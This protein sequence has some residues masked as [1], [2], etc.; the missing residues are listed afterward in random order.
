MNRCSHS[1]VA[2]ILVFVVFIYGCS[3]VRMVT[4]NADMGNP[5]DVPDSTNTMSHMP[6]PPPSDSSHI[7]A[8]TLIPKIEGNTPTSQTGQKRAPIQEKVDSPH[9]TTPICE[10]MGICSV[11]P[12]TAQGS[13]VTFSFDPNDNNH[14]KITVDLTNSGNAFLQSLPDDGLPHPYNFSYKFYFPVSPS[15]PNG[16]TLMPLN[17][18]GR[19]IPDN[20]PGTATKAQGATDVV[21]IMP[22]MPQ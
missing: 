7:P 14:I 12:L 13:H 22:L 15:D 16:N 19:Y 11:S 4:V 9:Q 17:L 2:F 20:M 21:I 3:P 5:S 6:V 18:G 1:L 8:D 10:G